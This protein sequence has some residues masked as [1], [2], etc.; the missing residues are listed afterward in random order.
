MGTEVG[1]GGAGGVGAGGTRVGGAGAGGAGAGPRRPASPALTV[2]SDA[3]ADEE[4]ACLAPRSQLVSTRS[5]PPDSSRGPALPLAFNHSGRSEGLEACPPP[6]SPSPAT[7]TSSL[8]ALEVGEVLWG[9]S[10][11]N[12]A[13]SPAPHAGRGFD[14]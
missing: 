4:V 10:R 12:D 14:A 7:T 8:Y 11:P 1:G 3:R 13:G 9:S 6:R 2:D 5:S